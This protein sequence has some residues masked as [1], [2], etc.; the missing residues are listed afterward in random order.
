MLLTPPRV[1]SKRL[2]AKPVAKS[3]HSLP[4]AMI[5]TTTPPFALS[6]AQLRAGLTPHF[7]A[8]PARSYALEICGCVKPVPLRATAASFRAH[9]VS[10]RLSSYVH[11][12]RDRLNLDND[13]TG[14]SVFRRVEPGSTSLTRTC[15][16]MSKFSGMFQAL[17][18]LNRTFAFQIAPFE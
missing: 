16:L 11:V 12:D 5:R 17:Q 2:A 4:R 18:A 8:E 7:I 6:P 13:T 15:R 10:L 14:F 9:F 3:N 1:I